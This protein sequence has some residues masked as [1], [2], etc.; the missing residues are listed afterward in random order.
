MSRRLG[1]R[2]SGR[3][4][5][6]GTSPQWMYSPLQCAAAD[7]DRCTFFFLTA[8][9][10]GSFCSQAICLFESKIFFAVIVDSFI[11]EIVSKGTK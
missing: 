10:V 2:R 11:V 4:P 1:T 3:R 5:C 8:K 9:S 6:L 7:K